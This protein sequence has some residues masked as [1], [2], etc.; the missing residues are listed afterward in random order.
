MQELCGLDCCSK[1]A[2]RGTRCD[3]CAATDG[4]PCGGSCI[5]AECVKKGGKEA[6]A[7]QKKAIIEEINALSIPGL[8]VTGLNL[9]SGAYV[10]LEY[11]LPNGSTVRLLRDDKVYWGN[12]IEKPGD[13]R[14]YG[15]VADESMLLVCEYGE[16]GADPRIILFKK[17]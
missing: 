16:N 2:L 17:R 4:H 13:E 9:L 6:L 15:V 7:A 10:N 14:C 11:P 3:G 1:C 5:A 12:Q 8:Q